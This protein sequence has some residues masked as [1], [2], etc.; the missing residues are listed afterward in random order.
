MTPA[1]YKSFDATDLARLVKK[2]EVCPEDLLG[3]AIAIVETENPKLNAVVDRLYDQASGQIKRGLPDGVFRGVPFLLKDLGSHYAGVPS[4]YGS[5]AFA[6]FRPSTHSEITL[7]YENAGLVL[8]GKTNTSE[9]GLTTSAESSL[10]GQTRNPWDETRSA[11]GSSGGAAAAVA[12]GMMPIAEATDGGGSIRV[13]EEI[14]SN[15]CCPP[16]GFG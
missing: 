3:V 16:E 6:D 4:T 13:P 2:R 5:K 12:S 10:F 14:L 15:P 1:E 8:I 7:R 11:G 9:F